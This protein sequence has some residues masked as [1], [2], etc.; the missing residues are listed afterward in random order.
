[1]KISSVNWQSV[2]VA[3]IAGLGL[4]TLWYHPSVFGS[5][6]MDFMGVAEH[7][8]DTRKIAIEFVQQ[9]LTCLAIA[10]VATSAGMKTV[11]DAFKLSVV[12]GLGVCGS[13]VLSQHTWA[14]LPPLLTAVDIGHDYVNALVFSLFACLWR[15]A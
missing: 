10:I 1:M 2:T 7:E 13:I 9:F 14:E 4:G 15:K 12:I 5:V 6:F 11:E 3:S 8:Y